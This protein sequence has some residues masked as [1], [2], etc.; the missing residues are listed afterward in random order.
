MTVWAE[1]DGHQFDLQAL[2]GRFPSG[3]PRIVTNDEGTFMVTDALDDVF[4]EGGRL[5]DVAQEQLIQLNGWTALN[6]AGYRPVRLRN[7]FHR[8]R[9][10]EIV[11]IV[12]GDEIRMRDSVT[13]VMLAPVEI[14]ASAFGVATVIGG[15]PVEPPPPPGPKHLA[16]NDQNVR[17]LLAV[18]GKAERLSWSQLYKVFEIVR[19]A[20][21]GGNDGLAE[22]GWTTKAELSAFTGSANNHLVSGIHESRHARQ[23]GG[24]PKQTMA[25]DEAQT[26]IR[27]LARAW[28]SSL[29]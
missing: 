11:H 16:R 3:D 10:P 22:T 13:V 1:L 8:D 21:G 6:D 14:R 15:I 24:P 23:S 20:V 17:D 19:A 2:A 12:T 7:K 26:Y 28:F 9:E 5:V 27:N 4:G 25:L 18:I 29:P